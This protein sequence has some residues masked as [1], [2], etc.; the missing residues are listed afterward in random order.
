MTVVNF[1]VAVAVAVAVAAPR[2]TSRFGAGPLLATGLAVTAIACSHHLG[3]PP[4][5]PPLRVVRQRTYRPPGAAP[6]SVGRRP[7][8]AGSVTRDVTFVDVDDALNDDVD[9]AY[10]TKYRR[11]AENTLNRVTRPQARAITMN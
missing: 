9:T 3:R 8:Q 10:R 2:L 4:R 7:G 1:A 5:R 6:P 11:H